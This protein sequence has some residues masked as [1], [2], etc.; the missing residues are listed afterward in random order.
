M[1]APPGSF[2][3]ESAFQI[4]PK[5]LLAQYNCIKIIISNAWLVTDSSINIYWM[6][7]E[8]MGRGMGHKREVEQNLIVVHMSVSIIL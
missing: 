2:T 3:R 4:E 8:Q 5:H 6:K 7:N 1:F